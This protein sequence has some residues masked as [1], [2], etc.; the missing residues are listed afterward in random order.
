MR[1]VKAAAFEL[2]ALIV[3]LAAASAPLLPIVR[4]TASKNITAHVLTAS[5]LH[6]GA[7]VTHT[8]LRLQI[9]S[10]GVTELATSLCQHADIAC[11]DGIPLRQQGGHIVHS[12]AELEAEAVL[13]LGAM[14]QVT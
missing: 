11:L 14:V 6:D 8:V 9:T 13:W 1:S 12:I 7:T 4:D 2:C 3:I 5:G 10:M